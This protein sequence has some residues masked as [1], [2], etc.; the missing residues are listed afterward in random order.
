MYMQ[1]TSAAASAIARAEHIPTVPYI[2]DT[3][4]AQQPVD[5][6]AGMARFK[7][8]LH[9]LGL[10]DNEGKENLPHTVMTWL[11]VTFDTLTMTMS[12]PLPKIADCLSTTH[13]WAQK[14][15]ATKTEL[16]QY[17]GK[18]LHICECC[19]T[20]RL[21]VNRMLQTLRR[22]PEHGSICL[23]SE[24][25]AEVQW[26]LSYLSQYNGIQMIP[27]SPTLQV[28]L[29]VDSCLTGGG[30]HFGRHL[31][32]THY[33]PFILRRTHSISD[34]EIL[35][36]VVAIRLWAPLLAGHI[37]KVLCDNSA[38]VSVVQTG[39]GRAPFLLACAR[40]IWRA[41]ALFKFELRVA[42]LPGTD[43]HL[44]DILSRY[45]NDESCRAQVDAYID[46]NQP[47]I[48]SVPDSLFIIPS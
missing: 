22:V 8:L 29:V 25:E 48:H 37:V 21:F 39:R 15:H 4:S 46:N 19:P 34:L 27:D 14:S 16:R 24:F 44:A 17:L 31:Y 43:N 6:W 33:P 26:I 10:Q 41:T 40:E 5:A 9:E 11:G 30:G 47:T 1:R 36:L 7:A 3:A 20:L 42:H 32:F 38:A 45:H 12:V 2:D 13:L 28:P 23:D 35:N 18:L